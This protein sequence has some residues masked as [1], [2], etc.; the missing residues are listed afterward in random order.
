VRRLERDDAN[1]APTFRNKKLHTFTR[2]V[3]QPFQGRPRRLGETE[4][5]LSCE[6]AELDEASS[7]PVRATGALFDEPMRR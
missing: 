7:E 1:P 6:P 2:P 3:P 5:P 4:A